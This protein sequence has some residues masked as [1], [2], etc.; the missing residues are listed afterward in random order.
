[1]SGTFGRGEIVDVLYRGDECLVLTASRCIRL[2]DIGTA[3]F[4]YLD[5]PRTRQEFEAHLVGHFGAPPDGALDDLVSSLVGS[6]LIT[7]RQ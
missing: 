5:R 6:G 3:A 1:M 4:A 7:R 2:S